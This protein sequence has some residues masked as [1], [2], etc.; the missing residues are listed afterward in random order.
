MSNN[1]TQFINKCENDSSAPTAKDFQSTLK[2]ILDEIGA[3]Q[4]CVQKANTFFGSSLSD[5][6]ESTNINLPGSNSPDTQLKLTPSQFTAFNN[7]S[8]DMSSDGCGTLIINA[9]KITNI[10]KRMNCIIQQNMTESQISSRANATITIKQLEYDCTP[11][12]NMSE[13]LNSQC[14][15]NKEAQAQTVLNLSGAQLNQTVTLTVKNKLEL[16]SDAE[17]DLADMQKEI[18]K[19]IV[20]TKL[21]SDNNFTELPQSVKDIVAT[22]TFID[23]NCTNKAINEK[24]QSAS[25]NL[26]ANANVV[27]Q[28]IGN[29]NASNLNINQNVL[30][31]VVTEVLCNDAIKT[32]L[33]AATNITETYERQ[34]NISLKQVGQNLADSLKASQ[35]ANVDAISSL[36]RPT[37]PVPTTPVPTPSSP[38]YSYTL[39]SSTTPVPKTSDD[40]NIGWIIFWIII[41]L[42]ILVAIGLFFLNFI[43]PKIKKKI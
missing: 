31:S 11:Y 6:S 7:A 1:S 22:D 39:S 12:L 33:T 32:A 43:L 23:E 21:T 5:N 2:D 19:T 3:N 42:L 41:T 9:A 10:K 36:P 30:A 28:F 37:S 17:I 20:E 8:S 15:K 29:L 27:I 40:T 13:A 14:L 24:V 34:T 38:N 35:K 25:V 18:A 4:K 26:D 16:S